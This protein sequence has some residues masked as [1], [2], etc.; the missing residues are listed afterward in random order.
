MNRIEDGTVAGPG[1]SALETIFTFV[2]VPTILFV[3]ISVIAYALT[4]PRKS[5]SSSITSI[6]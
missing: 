1:L 2:V 6:Q 3:V 5:K 4:G